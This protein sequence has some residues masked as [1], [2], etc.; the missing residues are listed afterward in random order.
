MKIQEYERY[1]EYYVRCDS[2]ESKNTAKSNK[3][4]KPGT[5]V[6]ES[7]L[8]AIFTINLRL[9]KQITLSTNVVAMID[10]KTTQHIIQLS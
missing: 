7:E 5:T 1:Q 2:L 3:S 10:I 4:I 9:L 6:N 8:I